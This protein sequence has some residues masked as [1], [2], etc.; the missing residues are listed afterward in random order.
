MITSETIKEIF[1]ALIKAQVGAE[2]PVK[3]N[4]GYNYKYADLK[5]VLRVVRP[6]LEK[7]GLGII[8]KPFTDESRVGVTTRLIHE[9]GEWIESTYSTPLKKL[10]P[11]D[12][13]S[14]ITYYRR[15]AVLGALNLAPEDDDAET[16]SKNR[17]NNQH[18]AEGHRPAT[19]KQ[20]SFVERLIVQNNLQDQVTDEWFDNLTA[21]QANE[22]IGRYRL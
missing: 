1:P 6:V 5:E 19:D 21:K 20:K 12:V 2:R 8:Q 18:A 14:V 9:S 11:Q 4:Q 15:Y 7:N 22:F 13:G 10:D 17:N 3:K 16:A